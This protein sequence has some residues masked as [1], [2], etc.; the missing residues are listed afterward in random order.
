MSL[1]GSAVKPKK[2]RAAG[3]VPIVASSVH[4]RS[5]PKN[6]RSDLAFMTPANVPATTSRFSLV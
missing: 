5:W 1:L 6:Q 3:A 4:S 2:E